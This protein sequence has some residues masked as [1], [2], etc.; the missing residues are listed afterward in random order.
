MAKPGRFGASET[1]NC[2]LLPGA[3]QCGACPMGALSREFLERLCL[4]EDEVAFVDMEAD[5]EHFGGRE[6]SLDHL[7]EA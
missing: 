7:K 1:G 4:K 2:G 3:Y 6:T 5:I